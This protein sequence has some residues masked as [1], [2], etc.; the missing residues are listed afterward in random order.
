MPLPEMVTVPL[1]TEVPVFAVALTATLPLLAPLPGEVVIQ[2]WSSVTV[3]LTLAVT[4][5]GCEDAAAPSDIDVGET[6]RLLVPPQ[7]PR[8]S[9]ASLRPLPAPAAFNAMHFDTSGAYVV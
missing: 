3:Q 6:V 5:T 8:T 7:L 9:A 2:L 1:R 4:A